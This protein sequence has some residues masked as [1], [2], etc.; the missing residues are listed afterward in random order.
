[1]KRGLPVF[2]CGEVSACVKEREFMEVSVCGLYIIADEYFV[3]F[4]NVRHMSNKHESRP[5]YLAVKNENG[6]I[7][8]V[9]LSSQVDKYKAKISED[10]K[11]HGES[12]FYY[13]ARMKGRDSAF[14]VGNAIPVIERY[15]KKPFTVKGEPF[16][17]QDKKD[18][19]KVKSK[20]SRYLTMVR[21]GKMKP[22][23][24]ILS[25]ERKLLDSLA[26]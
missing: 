13:I 24:D 4:P 20:L 5:Y 23:V 10:T 19:K 9:P 6:I 18:V 26:E 25:I 2:R 8:V 21:N 14:L 3:D 22:V 12:L 15:I 16:V 1:V 7:W 17:I 11:K